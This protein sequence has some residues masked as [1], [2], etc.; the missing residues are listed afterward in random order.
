M[1]KRIQWAISIVSALL[2]IAHI[3]WPDVTID[4][5]TLTLFIIAVVPW[6]APL[7]KTIEF[8]GGWKIEFQDL[9][10]AL[11]KAEEAGLLSP[12]I[13]RGGGAEFTF[14]MISDNDPN[15]ALAGLRIEIEKRLIN[16][17]EAQGIQVHKPSVSRLLSLL[18]QKQLLNWQETSVLRD[19]I[20]LLNSAVHGAAVDKKAFDWAMEIGPRLLAVL[21]ERAEVNPA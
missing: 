20:G 7:F 15:L 5:I 21:E 3:R 4:A 14:Q 8:P 12:K 1:K 17:A 18:E 19:L 11:A 9:E 16:I 2:A 10:R 6:L 13:A